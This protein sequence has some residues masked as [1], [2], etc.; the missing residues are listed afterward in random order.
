MR[1]EKHWKDIFN[2]VIQETDIILEV[3]DAR[4]PLGTHNN[5]I[6]EFVKS[7]RPEINI[8][9]ILNKS[10]IIPKPVIQDWKRYF[11]SKGY[12]IFAVS[13]RYN[14]GILELEKFLRK[15]VIRSNTNIL[16]V[17][18]PNTGKSSLIEALTRGTK[19]AGVSNKAGFTRVIQ[20]IKLTNKMYLIDT[21]GVIPIDETNEKEMAIKSCMVVDKL[22]DPLAVVEAIYTL[23]KREQF[24]QT[25]KIQLEPEDELSEII[26][27]IGKRYGRLKAGGVVNED[28]VC[29]LIIRDWQKN[30]LHYYTLPP[31]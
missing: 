12:K 6:E 4:N 5:T 8:Y 29:K 15:T 10:D 24:E 11:Q 13:A 7:H 1:T 20:K 21:P 19:K 26:E 3:L 28:E 9:L 27:K 23:I 17:G 2:T 30:K 31:K 25:Y 22:E 16:I 18:Y 14:R